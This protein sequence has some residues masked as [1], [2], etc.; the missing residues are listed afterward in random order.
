M[1]CDKFAALSVKHHAHLTPWL[2]YFSLILVLSSSSQTNPEIATKPSAPIQSNFL[3]EA[4]IGSAQTVADQVSRKIKSIIMKGRTGCWAALQQTLHISQSMSR[5]HH[6]ISSSMIGRP[7]QRAIPW[8]PGKIQSVKVCHRSP[9]ACTNEPKAP[10]AT[11]QK[12]NWHREGRW[13]GP[14]KMK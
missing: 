3:N 13:H 11:M 4:D 7:Q 12:F 5:P 6:S 9:L 14:N 10:H 1:V 8:N 2:W